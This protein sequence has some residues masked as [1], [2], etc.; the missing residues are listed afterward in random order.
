MMVPLPAVQLTVYIIEMV[1]RVR[2]GVVVW[3]TGVISAMWSV[4]Q[5]WV[6]FC[7]VYVRVSVW[8]QYGIVAGAAVDIE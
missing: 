2:R 8:S 5:V 6:T 3:V 7:V 1:L 4:V